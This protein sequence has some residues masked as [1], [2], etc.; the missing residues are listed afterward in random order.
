MKGLRR[1][2]I[3]LYLPPNLAGT[4]ISNRPEHVKRVVEG[5]LK[6]LKTDC[7]DLLY[8]HRVDPNVPTEDVA[9]AVKDLMTQGKVLYWGLSEIGPDTLRR[10]HKALSF[11]AVQSEYS[12]LWHEPKRVVLP[13]CEELGIGFVS[14]SPLGV[15][16]LTGWLDSNTRFA[17]VDFRSTELRFAPDNLMHNFALVDIVKQWAE[18]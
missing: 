15:Q 2:A 8:Q 5:M 10:A 12:M 14:E 13:T 3:K 7:I 1:F 9:G 16:F 4:L 17:A 11:A 18:R 6:R